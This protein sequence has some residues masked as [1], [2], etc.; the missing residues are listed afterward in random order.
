[1]WNTDAKKSPGSCCGASGG[2]EADFSAPNL[3]YVGQ[4]K[5][6]SVGCGAL[7][8]DIAIWEMML[9]QKKQYDKPQHLVLCTGLLS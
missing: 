4:I 8:P 1:M 2:K 9:M 7:Q 5:G 3:A 6:L